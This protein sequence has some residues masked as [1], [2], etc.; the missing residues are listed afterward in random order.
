MVIHLMSKSKRWWFI[1]PSRQPY[2]IA[3]VFWRNCHSYLKTNDFIELN[4]WHPTEMTNG[5]RDPL[6]QSMWSSFLS[7]QKSKPDFMPTRW[8]YNVNMVK[9]N[10]NQYLYSPNITMERRYLF[11]AGEKSFCVVVG[12]MQRYIW[13]ER[14]RNFVNKIDTGWRIL[15][16][17][18]C[19]IL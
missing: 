14:R 15:L 11:I 6:Y 19:E 13:T 7:P 16:W 9:E 8:R 1:Y 3:R 17:I 4:H 12:S 10:I 5:K 18:W 2:T